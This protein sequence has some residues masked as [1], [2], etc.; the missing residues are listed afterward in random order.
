MQ[1]DHTARDRTSRNVLY[2]TRT[3]H[4]TSRALIAL[5]WF[6]FIQ[7]W[8]LMSMTFSGTSLVDGCER[9]YDRKHLNDALQ[10]HDR[11]GRFGIQRHKHG[12]PPDD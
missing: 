5:N 7:L 3:L 8:V 9:Q 1:E 11:L 4:T 2:N 10:H 12:L 6:T